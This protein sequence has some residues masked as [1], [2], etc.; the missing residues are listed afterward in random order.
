MESRSGVRAHLA[1]TLERRGYEIRAAADGYE[2]VDLLR[3]RGAPDLILLAA[4]LPGGLDG[5]QLCKLLR[6]N[7][8]T[9][10]TPILLLSEKAG[11]FRKMRGGLAGATA[12]LAAPFTPEELL[13]EVERLCPV[14]SGAE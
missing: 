14:T 12:E 13:R 3:D 7:P 2:A 1:E 10:H 6:E 11:L 4:D 9:T 5:Y 8:T